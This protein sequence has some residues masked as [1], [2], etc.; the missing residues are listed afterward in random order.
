MIRTYR[1]STFAELW[2]QLMLFGGWVIVVGFGAYLTPSPSGHGTHQQL[3]LAPCP[4]IHFLNRPCPGCGLTTSWTATIHGQ[5]GQAFNSHWL[6]PPAFAI[7]TA[8][9]LV[10]LWGLVTRHRIDFSTR[11]Y[12]TFLIVFASIFLLYGALRFFRVLPFPY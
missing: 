8:C 5:F 4:S 6:G 10:A 11:A 7:F 1:Q 9:A 12:N 3:G 2:P